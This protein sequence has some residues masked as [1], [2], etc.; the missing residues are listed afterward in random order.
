MGIPRVIVRAS[1]P[2]Q[3]RIL[4]S[5]GVQEILAPEAEF[6]SIVAERLDESQPARVLWNCPD[7]YE[8][9]E[10][11][12]P[13]A[14]CGRSLG[15]IDLTTRYNLRLITI[16]RTYDEG[17]ETRS[18]SSAFRVPI[19]WSKKPTPWWSLE[20]LGDVNRF[21]EVNE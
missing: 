14:S 12:A 3:E 13:L 16:R 1:G 11:Q 21:L 9:A 6:A 20:R 19:P 7:D 18:T 2:H 5:L 15:D 17:G 4:R 8:I 10:I